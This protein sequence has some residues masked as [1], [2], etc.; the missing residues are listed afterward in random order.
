MLSPANVEMHRA[1]SFHPRVPYMSQALCW[2]L[3]SVV[4]SSW[5][6]MRE[7]TWVVAENTLNTHAMGH[8]L[9]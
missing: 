9:E 4:M 2:G 5:D 6:V 7:Y 8:R 3:V 1:G